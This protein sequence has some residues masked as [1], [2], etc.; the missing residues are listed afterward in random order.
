MARRQLI[1]NPRAWLCGAG[2]GLFLASAAWAALPPQPAKAHDRAGLVLHCGS[3][4]KC[5]APG[6][7]IGWAAPGRYARQV[8]RLKFTASMSENC[9]PACQSMRKRK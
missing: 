5:L 3:F 4:S 8:A 9:R 6:Y 1:R 2:L 7:R